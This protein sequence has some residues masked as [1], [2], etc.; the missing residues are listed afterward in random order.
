MDDQGIYTC[1][2]SSTGQ[3]STKLIVNCMH[4]L[5][6]F[7]LPQSQTIFAL[8]ILAQPHISPS[9]PLLL[10]PVNRTFTLTCSLLCD[11]DINFNAFFWLINGELIERSN[12]D[13]QQEI[14]SPHTQRLT[15]YLN[16]KNLNFI[17]ANYTCAY[18]EKE[19][20]IF[21][22]RRTSE[23]QKSIIEVNRTM[24]VLFVFSRRRI[25]SITSTTWFISTVSI[26]NP[27]RY[28]S[29]TGS[30]T[31]VDTMDFVLLRVQY[32]MICRNL[33]F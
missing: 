6:F 21:V 31:Y 30:T 13:Y 33:F 24:Y 22:R 10:Y 20:S 32:S 5:F 18:G 8:W 26:S 17:E 25:P 16:K 1:K 23:W 12:E 11:H 9:S 15:V 27:F 28:Q 19:A 2:S 3:H 4:F 14:L 29:S 7:I